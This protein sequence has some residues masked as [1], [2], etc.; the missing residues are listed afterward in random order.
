MAAK[1][2]PIYVIGDSHVT[3]F[4]GKD[5]IVPVWNEPH[6]D[7]LPQFK[8]YRLGAM[9]AYNLATERH[10]GREKLFRLLDSLPKR[11][12]VMLVF[13]EIDCRAHI[14]KQARL[15]DRAIAEIAYD[16]GTRYASVVKEVAAL[17]KTIVWGATPQ[18]SASHSSNKFP[19]VGTMVE[20]NQATFYF[21]AAVEQ[22][23]LL[24][25]IAFASIFNEL[26][27]TEYI[28]KE[29]YFFDTAHL[30]Q[31]ALPFALKA[32]AEHLK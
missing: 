23:C 15:Q 10:E 32:L 30:N 27:D 26:V 21:N 7:L 28:S 12:T 2:K 17:R 8:T 31:R 1:A 14:V 25:G 24:S 29:S 6:E 9:L 22:E 19:T 18:S 4:S 11:S 20:R 16:V 3:L 5:E 13:G